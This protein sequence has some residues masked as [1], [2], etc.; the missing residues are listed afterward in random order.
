MSD[1]V[2]FDVLETQERIIRGLQLNG[3]DDH[4]SVKQ[5]YI[6]IRDAPISEY[7]PEPETWLDEHCPAILITPGGVNAPEN[8][9]TNIRDDV[10]YQTL[11]Q[12]LDNTAGRF[13]RAA[14]K[15]HLWWIQQ[16]RRAIHANPWDNQDDFGDAKICISW[17]KDVKVVD[18]TVFWKHKK[19]IRG[20]VTEFKIREPRDSA[21]W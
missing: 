8:A 21:N 10:Y 16:I 4:P 19:F 12:I 3:F 11:I 18:Q 9:G 2:F 5:D 13:N 15:S 20:I 17:S 1:V 14:L 7:E 6:E